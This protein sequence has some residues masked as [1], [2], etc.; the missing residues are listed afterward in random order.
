MLGVDG[1]V[2]AIDL[3]ERPVLGELLFF[4]VDNGYGSNQMVRSV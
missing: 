4:P 3:G 2:C 1:A